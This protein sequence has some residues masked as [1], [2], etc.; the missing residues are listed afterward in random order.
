MPPALHRRYQTVSIPAS[1]G[2]LDDG[3]T[4]GTVAGIV[5]GSVAGFILLLYLAYLGLGLN[6]KPA[7]DVTAT[8]TS[9]TWTGTE[10]GVT[11]RSRRSRRGDTIEVVEDQRH[12]P[13]DH[14]SVEESVMSASRTDGD[15]VVEVIEEHSSVDGRPPPRS[16]SRRSRGVSGSYRTVDPYGYGGE[17]SYDGR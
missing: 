13:R 8:A 1:Y 11:R 4:P 14:V 12:G 7:D 3:P 6:N 9:M 17:S 16:A 15:D 10:S 2:R 5:L